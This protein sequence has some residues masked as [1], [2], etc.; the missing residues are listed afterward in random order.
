[1]ITL[2]G[3]HCNTKISHHGEINKTKYIYYLFAL[4]VLTWN[5]EWFLPPNRDSTPFLRNP[6][7]SFGTLGDPVLPFL[8]STL[9]MLGKHSNF[10]AKK[11]RFRQISTIEHKIADDV[12]SHFLIILNQNLKLNSLFWFFSHRL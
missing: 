11:I 7:P 1:M 12:T 8:G 5:Q 3:F 2:S 6:R 4:Q 9:D 10:N